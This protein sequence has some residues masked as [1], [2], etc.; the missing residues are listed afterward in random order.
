MK[1][2]V[3]VC[4]CVLFIIDI[5]LKSFDELLIEHFTKHDDFFN[6][7]IYIYIYIYTYIY[8]YI[9]RALSKTTSFHILI[10]IY[11]YIYQKSSQYAGKSAQLQMLEQN[12][13]N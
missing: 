6:F 1:Q 9:H 3:E 11:I 4:N 2:S 8:T 7:Y 12:I 5:S 13:F 10:Y